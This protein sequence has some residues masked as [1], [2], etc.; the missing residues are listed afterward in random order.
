MKDYERDIHRHIEEFGCSVTSVVD[1]DGKEPTFSYSIGIAK[2]TSQPEVIVVG[3]RTEL[4][5][6]IINEYSRRAKAGEE[7][8]PGVLYLGFLEGFAVQFGHVSRDHRSE[9][10]RS[11]TWLH[12]TP[13]FSALQLI[14]PNTSG[15]WPWDDDADD[16]F[17][18]N[19]PLLAGSHS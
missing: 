8:A 9:Y 2:T 5:H 1:P 11:A 19:Q 6:W 16:W 18:A 15:V 4:G 14:Y 12:G 7:F 17:R 10:M 3:L 13:D